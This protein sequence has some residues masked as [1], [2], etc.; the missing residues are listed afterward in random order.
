MKT[1]RISTYCSEQQGGKLRLLS[2]ERITEDSIKNNGLYNGPQQSVLVVQSKVESKLIYYC[3]AV[4]WFVAEKLLLL[5]V[6]C[7][8]KATAWLHLS[9]DSEQPVTSSM[10]FP[11]CIVWDILSTACW[12]PSVHNSG[13]SIIPYML[14]FPQYTK[15]GFS[16]LYPPPQSFPSTLISW[17]PTVE[18]TEKT[19]ASETWRHHSMILAQFKRLNSWRRPS[20]YQPQLANCSALFETLY[21]HLSIISMVM[22]SCC[23][24]HCLLR[25]YVW[26][27]HDGCTSPHTLYISCVIIYI[28]DHTKHPFITLNTVCFYNPL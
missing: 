24:L 4:H 1:T 22:W 23:E 11:S 9:L 16:A 14:H 5:T 12:R 17:A 25:W 2:A 19:R 15:G 6:I 18:V 28:N 27:C 21:F 7:S 8:V 26:I 3:K 10:V 20:S 13:I